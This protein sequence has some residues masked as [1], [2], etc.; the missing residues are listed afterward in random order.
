MAGYRGGPL[1][2]AYAASKFAVEGLS[3]ALAPEVA[4]SRVRVISVAPGT[5]LIQFLAGFPQPA[6]GLS[7]A[8]ADGPV[9]AAL[10]RFE[11]KGGKQ[12]G[13]PDKAAERVVELVDGSNMGNGFRER[14]FGTVLQ[15]FLGK[16]CYGAATLKSQ[17]ICEDIQSS[18]EVAYSTDFS[19]G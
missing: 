2:T 8:C 14:G 16:D 12:S 11:A 3:E 10:A 13:D 15:V 9:A 1:A 19:E 5:F 4:P 6:A 17:Q 7:S 18:Q